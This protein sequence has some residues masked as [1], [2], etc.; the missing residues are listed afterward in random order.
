MLVCTCF[1]VAAEIGFALL[2][3]N[4]THLALQMRVPNN[5]LT[6]FQKFQER[7]KIPTAG[8]AK[9]DCIPLGRMDPSEYLDMD[10]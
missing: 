10:T 7:M 2:L 6:Y 8:N 1:S 9:N 4:L 5:I 3:Q